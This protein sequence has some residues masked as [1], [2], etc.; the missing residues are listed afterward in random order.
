MPATTNLEKIKKKRRLSR[1]QKELAWATEVNEDEYYG[2]DTRSA[3]DAP[4]VPVAEVVSELDASHDYKTKQDS[5]AGGRRRSHRLSTRSA[6]MS[7]RSAEALKS[8]SN[9]LPLEAGILFTMAW[10]PPLL[11]WL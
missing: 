5:A 11:Q 9:S 6:G 8:Y 2:V 1:L 7:A 10:L 4:E 3:A